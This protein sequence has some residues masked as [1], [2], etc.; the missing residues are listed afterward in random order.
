MPLLLLALL[1][2]ARAGRDLAA[3]VERQIDRVASGR[4]TQGV[5]A[6][7]ALLRRADAGEGPLD[8][9]LRAR[10]ERR[11]ATGS[12]DLADEAFETDPA[13]HLDAAFGAWERCVASGTPVAEACQAD[14]A[15]LAPLY[16]RR[17]AFLRQGLAEG[18]P[19]GAAEAR[20]RCRQVGI[21]APESLAGP[22]CAAAVART[23]DDVDAAVDAAE[24]ALQRLPDG[25]LDDVAEPLDDAVALAV[26][27]LLTE[28]ADVGGGRSLLDRL[29]QA[30]AG[31]TPDLPD[32][33][34][35]KASV[36]TLEARLEPARPGGDGDAD[37]WSGWLATLSKAGLH[38]AAVAESARA[39]AAHPDDAA[40][41]ERI[42]V[43]R[44][45]AAA[46][47]PAHAGDRIRAARDAFARCA[48]LDPDH[49][50]CGRNRDALD[51]TLNQ[52]G[53]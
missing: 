20:N 19:V 6:L 36:A 25:P 27:A 39:A 2:P 23:L 52:A 10:A 30:L 1:L 33:G 47:D 26:D 4:A 21:L 38:G 18:N 8:A 41:W 7:Q 28:R 29:D 48:E 44:N 53:G 31:R 12:V 9:T 13:G 43:V 17:A 34:R 37:A 50:R 11:I 46:V 51:A 45:N 40:L 42:G 16:R 35:M 24:A 32:V 5:P 22:A 49:P 3:E 15:V 14:A